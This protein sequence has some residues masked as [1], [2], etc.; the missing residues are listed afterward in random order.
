MLLLDESRGLGEEGLEVLVGT[1]P[2]RIPP[3]ATKPLMTMAGHA[4]PSVPG[5]FSKRTP[6]I[7]NVRQMTDYDVTLGEVLLQLC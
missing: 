4:L 6:I 5:G 7:D 3:K 2:N 1:Y